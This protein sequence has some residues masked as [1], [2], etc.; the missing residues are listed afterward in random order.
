N[1]TVAPVFAALP[2]TSTISC[3]ATAEFA[4]ASASD[5]CAGDV[6]LTFEDA[7]TEGECAGS[8][9]I[10]R[11]WTATDSCGNSATATQTINVQDT[12]APVIAQLP[13]AS[14]ISCPAAPEFAQ[15]TATDTCSDEVTL[16]FAD[17]TTDGACEG[18]YSI[19]RTWTA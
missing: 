7:T 12:T 15:A 5:N 4:Q 13:A 18:S 8:Y 10:T 16:T 6:T 19:T 11:T 2:E 9:S 14:T 17:V 3:P 1:D